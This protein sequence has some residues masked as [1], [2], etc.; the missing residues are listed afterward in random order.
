MASALDLKRELVKR[1]LYEFLKEFWHTFETEKYEDNWHIEYLCETFMWNVRVHLPEYILKDWMSDDDFT[2]RLETLNAFCAE[3]NTTFNIQN[4]RKTAIMDKKPK[5]LNINIAPRS[6]KSSIYNIAGGT[7]LFSLTPVKVLSISHNRELSTQMNSGRQKI[8]SSE[9]YKELFPDVQLV[10]N[11]TQKLIG[12]HNGQLSSIGFKITGFGG[13]IVIN[14][15]I[16]D[17]TE[18]SKDKQELANAITFYKDSLPSRIVHPDTSIIMNIQQRL[19]PGDITGV[20]QGNPALRK[21]YEFIVLKAIA[22]EDEV[23]VFPCSGKIKVRKKGE[24]LWERNKNLY[25]D[26]R[27]SNPSKYQ[28]QYQQNPRASDE[29]IVKDEDIQYLNWSDA[30]ELMEDP[31]YIY[32]SHDLAMSEGELAD[33]TGS[34]LAFRRGAKLLIVDSMKLKLSFTRQKEHI[35]TLE[36]EIPGIIQVIENKANAK[37]VIDDLKNDVPSL[38]PYEPGSKS[39][40]QRLELAKDRMRNVYFVKD[41]MG[42]VPERV[43]NLINQLL[44]YPY[45]SD[46]DDIDAFSMVVNYSYTQSR[47]GYFATTFNNRQNLISSDDTKFLLAAPET[48]VLGALTR[49]GNLWKGLKMSYDMLHDRFI[50]LDELVFISDQNEAIESYKEYFKDCRFIMDASENSILSM[51]ISQQ[52]FLIEPYDERPITVQLAQ[53]QVGFSLGKIMVGRQCVDTRRDIDALSLDRESQEK[54]IEKYKGNPG[55]VSCIR[56]IVYMMK[57]DSEFFDEKT[58]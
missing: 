5:Y 29:T 52:I 14:D 50:V 57:G 12:S 21:Q 58:I 16:I 44:K 45:V 27:D 39:K 17:A 3:N 28:T 31:D 15:D 23:F 46:D 26:T 41:S 47:G 11:T 53:L 6:S 40:S 25:F 8:L 32:A 13:D 38:V 42:N 2:K 49:V 24:L 19:A 55:L 51:T 20:I 48:D 1:S 34:V 43:Q 18:A 54:G 10:T 37:A 56:S 9:L 35:I 33:F 22:E 7:W 4:I 36:N 30:K